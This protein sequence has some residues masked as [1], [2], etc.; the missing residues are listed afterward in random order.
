LLDAVAKLPPGELSPTLA[1][2]GIDEAVLRLPE[3][4]LTFAQFDTLLDDLY[5]RLAAEGST[6][7]SYRAEQG[8]R[9]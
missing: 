2:A 7:S 9:V 4:V 1:S 8:G 3:Q 6:P 5:R